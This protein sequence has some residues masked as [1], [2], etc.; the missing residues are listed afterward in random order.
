MVR[1]KFV[2]NTKDT[3][4]TRKFQGFRSSVPGTRG[5]V[6]IY[7]YHNKISTLVGLTGWWENT[8]NKLYEMLE[9]DKYY[10]KKGRAE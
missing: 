1:K 5:K 3:P 7:M 2:M 4:I 10:G 8:H 6:Q 9:G